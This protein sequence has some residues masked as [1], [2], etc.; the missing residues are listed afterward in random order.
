MYSHKDLD[1]IFQELEQTTKQLTDKVGEGR[2][3]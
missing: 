2:K 1:K 3:L